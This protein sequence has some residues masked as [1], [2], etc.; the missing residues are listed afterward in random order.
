MAEDGESKYKLITENREL[1]DTSRG[2]TG[3]ATAF[4]TNGD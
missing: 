1:K 3:K 4:Y 2:V